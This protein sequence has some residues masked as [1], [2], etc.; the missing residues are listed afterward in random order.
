MSNHLESISSLGHPAPQENSL[1]TNPRMSLELC[2]L[3]SGSSGNATVLRSPSGVMLIDLGIGPRTTAQRLLGTG[4]KLA[5]V[6]AVCLT[7][8]DSDH[9]NFNWLP[10]LIRRKIRLF[11]H[12]EKG[13]EMLGAVGGDVA[14]ELGALIQ[15][16]ESGAFEPLAGVRVQP[17][18][19]A[20]DR[21]GSHGFV[22]DGFDYRIGFATDLG[23]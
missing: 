12:V 16:F 7:H 15:P 23:H 21:T 19:L 11:C 20:H 3:A 22:I 6:G 9:F 18:A 10:T 8:L 5:D 17:F 13:R 2:I 4:V 1:L 14:R